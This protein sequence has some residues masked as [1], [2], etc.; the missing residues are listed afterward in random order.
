MEK[1]INR[2]LTIDLPSGQSAFLWGPRKTGKSTLLKRQFPKS[3]YVD[4]LKTDLFFELQSRPH[5]LRER[6]LER[7]NSIREYPIII[8]EIQKIPSL[9]DE[10]HW[11][12]ENEGLSFILCG[13]SARKLKRTHANL[14]GGRAWIYHLYPFCFSELDDYDLLRACNNGLIPIHYLTNYT[15]KSFQGYINGYLKEE[16]Q[17]EGLVRNLP[18]FSRFMESIPY[19][20]GEMINYD[21]IARDCGVSSPTVKSYYQIL[22]DTWLGYFLYPYR[23]KK[24]RDII[25]ET[26]KF[27]FFDP[28]V[29]NYIRKGKISSLKGSLAGNT[30]EHICFMELMAYNTYNDL[31][32]EFNYWRTT[33]GHEV[34]FVISE[35]SCAIEVKISQ[36]IS[37]KDL[38]ALFLFIDEYGFDNNYVVCMESQDRQIN[39]NKKVI[40]ILNWKSFLEKLWSHQII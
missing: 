31:E 27:Y 35:K 17:Q 3:Y 6:I 1:I 14:L 4:L 39:Y 23:I 7:N 37:K 32:L 21:N 20:S 22:L 15:K 18:A 33:T 5:L 36:K 9:L 34:D 12:I 16:I 11:L 19:S 30:F 2:Y 8:D 26:P 13:S 28:G 25:R 40:H 29:L 24:G 38:N 10:V